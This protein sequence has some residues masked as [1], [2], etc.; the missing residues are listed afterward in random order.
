MHRLAK[1]G[2]AAALVAGVSSVAMAQA[3]PE[4]AIRA[5]QA[6]MRV[7]ALNFGPMGKMGAGEIPF[8]RDAFAAYATR[9]EAVVTMNP[10]NFFV[11]GTDQPVAGAK[12]AN[13]T[14]ARPE[15]WQSPEKFKSAMEKMQQEVGKLARAART[16][17]EKTMK[18]Q[19]G[20][21]GKTCKGCHDDY[22]SK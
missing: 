12:I 18:V 2:L 3:K 14:D 17:D 4:E 11:P 6:I 16:G 22:R 20:E 7:V 5:R 1:I 19:A 9:L 10:Q 15:I 21:V 13:F 8:N